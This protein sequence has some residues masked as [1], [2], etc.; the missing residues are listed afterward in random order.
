MVL[1]FADRARE[2][3]G[4]QDKP[5]AQMPNKDLAFARSEAIV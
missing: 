4:P 5:A 1:E 2:R 3:T